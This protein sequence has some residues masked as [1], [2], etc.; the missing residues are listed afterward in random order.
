MADAAALRALVWDANLAA[1]GLDL[2]VLR[3]SD[4]DPIDARGIWCWSQQDTTP[5]GLDIRR[6][7]PTRILALSRATFD[8]V[9][10]GTRIVAPEAMGG[11]PVGWIVD[12][13]DR[14]ESDHHRLMVRRDTSA[15]P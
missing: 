14:L 8:A 6:H 7:D 3:L 13:P 15:D 5:G 2:T 11:T 10:R 4:V 1:H 9:P 12:G